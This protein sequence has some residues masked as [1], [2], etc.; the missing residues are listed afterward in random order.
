MSQEDGRMIKKQKGLTVA[1]FSNMN[2]I[3]FHGVVQNV[4]ESVNHTMG[5]SI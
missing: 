2:N 1:D 4:S 5:D 3:L